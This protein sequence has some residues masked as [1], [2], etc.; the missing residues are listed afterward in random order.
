MLEQQPKKKR[1]SGSSPTP[2]TSSTF[3]TAHLL[4]SQY[5][6][7]YW[8]QR[9]PYYFLFVAKV[10]GGYVVSARET[11][12]WCSSYNI[13]SCLSSSSS[14]R[15]QLCMN[16][17]LAWPPRQGESW[18]GT[19]PASGKN[20]ERRHVWGATML[21]QGLDEAG[22]PPRMSPNSHAS[23]LRRRRRVSWRGLG[24]FR[25]RSA[26]WLVAL[27]SNRRPMACEGP[28]DWPQKISLL[29]YDGMDGKGEAAVA[30]WQSPVRMYAHHPTIHF[31]CN[32]GERGS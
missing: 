10:A 9:V 30:S 26:L 19:R 4:I 24:V 22:S 29:F 13:P 27:G 20:L 12:P 31:L 5:E 6:R 14:S 25:S 21:G 11:K 17:V 3:D 1:K 8:L 23:R 16:L 15:G 18:W 7:W 2:D 28:T 32:C